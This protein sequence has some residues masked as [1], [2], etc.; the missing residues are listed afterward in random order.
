M[1]RNSLQWTKSFRI[2]RAVEHE[3]ESAYWLA[4]SSWAGSLF[5]SIYVYSM[6]QS[7]PFVTSGAS[8]GSLREDLNNIKGIC[9]I[10]CRY[11]LFCLFHY[12]CVVCSLGVE[13][14]LT[15]GCFQ[16]SGKSDN[17]V[18]AVFGS[19]KAAVRG[20]CSKFLLCSAEADRSW[21]AES[22]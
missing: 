17:C 21:K 7:W 6:W 15:S 2:Y 16:T 12:L 5:L 13:R 10:F 4:L 3:A 19:W 18:G 11:S 1:M 14:W 8:T 22:L 20:N 9:L